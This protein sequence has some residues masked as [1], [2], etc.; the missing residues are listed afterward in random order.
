MDKFGLFVEGFSHKSGKLLICGD[1]NYWVDDPPHKLFSA[2]F[3]ELVLHKRSQVTHLALVY[4]PGHPGTDRSFMDEFGLFVEGISHKSGKLLIC[5]DFNYWVDDP[6]HKSFSAEFLEL[7]DVNNFV[8][9]IALPTHASGHTLD[10]VLSPVGSS[11][12]K[13]VDVC[14]TATRVADHASIPFRLEF[15]PP[16][17]YIKTITYRSYCNINQALIGQEIENSL[18]VNNS[19]SFGTSDFLRSLVDA[20]CPKRTKR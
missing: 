10:L 16:P 9:H 13:D 15:P 19:E 3:M 7:V 1:F 4:R 6:P 18:C 8:N 20:Y 5:D 12:V 14:P 11:Y 17:S 2:E